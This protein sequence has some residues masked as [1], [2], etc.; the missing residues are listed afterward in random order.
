K[1]IPALI[2]YVNLYLNKHYQDHYTAKGID[3]K[4]LLK[5]TFATTLTLGTGTSRA[6]GFGHT[7]ITT[8]SG[9]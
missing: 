5:E 1:P 6:T 8:S 4:T 3:T 9:S 2:G 7:T